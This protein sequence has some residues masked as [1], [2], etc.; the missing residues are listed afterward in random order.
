MEQHENNHKIKQRKRKW[1]V[2]L[3]EKKKKIQ[4]D[5]SKDH[6]ELRK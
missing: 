1:A 4:N 2:H 5:G 3:K 6:P